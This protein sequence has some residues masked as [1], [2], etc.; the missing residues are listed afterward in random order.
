MAVNKGYGDIA[1]L[2]YAASPALHAERWLWT[3][4][5]G[6]CSS[7]ADVVLWLQGI[8]STPAT[9]KLLCRS[10]LRLY[11]GHGVVDKVRRLQYPELLKSYILLSDVL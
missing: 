3:E 9:L 4:P 6:R 2:I 8:A 11:F 5:A 1:E 7:D 10:K